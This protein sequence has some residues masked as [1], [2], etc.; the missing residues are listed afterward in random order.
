MSPARVTVAV[1]VQ[2]EKSCSPGSRISQIPCRPS[3]SYASQLRSRLSI[4]QSPLFAPSRLRS[5]HEHPLA[6]A[7]IPSFKRVRADGA[8]RATRED[9]T[10]IQSY[11]F[12]NRQF[13]NQQPFP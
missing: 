3:T 12:L 11:Q 2:L 7:A 1:R 6:S 5:R 4:L 9:W 13:A 8:V 10:A